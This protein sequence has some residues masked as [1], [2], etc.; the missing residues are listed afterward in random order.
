MRSKQ[1]QLRICNAMSKTHNFKNN[2]TKH[3]TYSWLVC[4]PQ[5]EII[6]QSVNESQS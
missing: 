2:F 1:A 4:K 5:P 6:T 3:F